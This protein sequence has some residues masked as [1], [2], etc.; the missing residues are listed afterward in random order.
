[1]VPLV[2]GPG[3]IVDVTAQCVVCMEFM[4]GIDVTEIPSDRLA[5]IG[6]E[7]LADELLRAY[8]KQ[9]LEDGF[10]HADPHPGNILL[11]DDNRIAMLDLGMTS[12]VTP[13]LQEQLLSL[14]IS[15]NEGRG[16]DAA[17]TAIKIGYAH[18]LFDQ[19]RFREQMGELVM[20]TQGIHLRELDM[21]RM[22]LE[23]G[24]MAG[25]TGL[26]V[27]PQMTMIGK[28]LMHLDQVGKALAPGFDPNE[29]VRQNV[30]ELVHRRMLRS[31]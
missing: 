5:A 18:K 10:F 20:Q 15:I 3:P 25:D 19:G 21:G 31:M 14:L 9:V 28:M 7:Q 6:G 30:A 11:T 1:G 23:I 17:Q 16:E 12:R 4:N 13:V 2:V 26:R 8:L 29:T 27:P 24:R 22:L